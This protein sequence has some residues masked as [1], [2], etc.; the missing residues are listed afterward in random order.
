MNIRA[1]IVIPCFNNALLTRQC[2]KN[3]HEN[4]DPRIYEIIIVDDASTDATKTLMSSEDGWIRVVRNHENLGFGL[5]CNEGARMA[6]SEVLVFLNNDAFV[7]P[8]W[9]DPLLKCFDEDSALGA[10]QPKLLFP[11][12]SVGDAGGLVFADGKAWNYG[13]GQGIADSP[14]V[15]VRRC[16]DYVSGACLAV[17]KEAFESVGGFDPR[18][19][20][21]YY[22]DT[23]LSFA[24]EKQGWKLLYEPAS[25]VVHIEGATS[26]TD[27]DKG[28]KRYQSVNEIKFK[29]K[30]AGELRDRPHLDPAIVDRW[31]FR[32]G[33]RFAGLDDS[34]GVTNRRNILVID[35]YPPA[36]DRS[37]GG[38]RM[39]ELLKRFRELGHSV[40][41]I[42][43]MGIESRYV[44]HLSR[45]GIP[46]F[47]GNPA[48]PR[49]SDP[50][51]FSAHRPSL[52][53]LLVSGGYDT[54]IISPWTMGE[55]VIPDIRGS[56]SSTKIVLD[57]CD[58]HFLRL[59]REAEILG[60]SHL[61]VAQ[62]KARE[63]EVYRK[64]DVLV[65]TTDS[66]REILSR[67]LEGTKIFTIQNCHELEDSG[68]GFEGREG[69]LFVGNFTHPPNLDA[70]RWWKS[71]VM[72][73][74]R[75]DRVGHLLTVVG[76]DPNGI[77]QA[78][79]VPG[80]EVMGAA[81]VLDPFYHRARVVVAPLRYGA[82]MKG[83]VGEAL[84][85]GTPL[86]AS[87]IAVEG[88]NLTHGKNVMIAESPG[89]FVQAINQL[90]TSEALWTQLREA[91]REYVEAEIGTAAMRQSADELL[92]A[93]WD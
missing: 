17:R 11:N 3:L 25:V 32:T 16:P 28:I 2:L 30:W 18:Y 82:G 7:M 14:L 13:K 81:D 67:H 61:E 36:F 73:H 57:T 38:K 71:D 44:L 21:A 85:F 33:R 4:T 27:T 37:S 87:P 54:V 90:E 91:G 80:V 62:L 42:A 31:A 15:N 9:L 10:V 86:V 8:N 69:L 29:E 5:S 72:S 68:P 88:M 1:S 92:G 83:K 43:S 77:A 76:N 40:S 70:V 59:E 51:Y 45:Y 66:D 58:V 55:W 64:C 89:E 48:D 65:C 60:T 50:A 93:M 6:R 22:E 84:S 39:Y 26:G 78:E 63:L 75:P 23:D 49:F 56:A 24:L 47:G 34:H 35:G 52:Q 41:F 79:S 74:L 46:S 19:A 12:G 53:K 20:P